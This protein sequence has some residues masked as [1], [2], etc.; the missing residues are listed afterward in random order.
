MFV[1]LSSSNY[2]DFSNF[3]GKWPQSRSLFY[4]VFESALEQNVNLSLINKLLKR[5]RC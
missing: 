1:G 5:Y 3:I 4:P 2:C